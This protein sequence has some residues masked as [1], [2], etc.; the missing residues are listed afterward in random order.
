[1][2][3]FLLDAKTD[4]LLSAAAQFVEIN[5]HRGV[6]IFDILHCAFD[7]TSLLQLFD[8]ITIGNCAELI[9][10]T[11]RTPT[12]ALNSVFERGIEGRAINSR[13]SARNNFH[14]YHC[15]GAV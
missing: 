15:S 14:T 6:G 8:R 2:R 7:K 3:P 9:K 1:M 12:A 4:C 5:N 10:A 13:L 11:R